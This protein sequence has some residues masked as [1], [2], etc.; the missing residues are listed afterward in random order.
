M[1]LFVFGWYDLY[2]LGWYGVVGCV[3]L[4]LAVCGS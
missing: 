2:K 3:W 4:V 1:L